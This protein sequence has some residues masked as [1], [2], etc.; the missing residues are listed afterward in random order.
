MFGWWWGVLN[1]KTCQFYRCPLPSRTALLT[2][3]TVLKALIRVTVAGSQRWLGASVLSIDDKAILFSKVLHMINLDTDT[4]LVTEERERIEAIARLNDQARS[5]Q[6][7]RLFFTSGVEALGHQA[8][9]M[10]LVA[11]YSDFW[12]DNDLLGERDFWVFTFRDVKLYWK[13]DYYDE[14]MINGSP[15]PA[16]PNLTTRVLTILLP[17]EW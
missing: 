12:P 9:I 2:S 7:V 13:V 4:F 15:D 16:D 11:T 3:R 10:D 14:Q 1:L 8:Q 6:N 17:I 5:G